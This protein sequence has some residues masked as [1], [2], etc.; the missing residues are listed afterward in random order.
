MIRERKRGERERGERGER[1]EREE[2]ERRERGE[3][4]RLEKAILSHFIAYYLCT[5]FVI[6]ATGSVLVGDKVDVQQEIVI[7]QKSLQAVRPLSKQ[8][9]TKLIDGAYSIREMPKQLHFF[10]SLLIFFLPVALSTKII[11]GSLIDGVRKPTPSEL[12]FGYLQFFGFILVLCI[13]I[14][15][16]ISHFFF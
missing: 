11:A 3:R 14:R 1:E 15:T 7:L 8:S 10:L 16:L 13:I 6:L 9:L 2:R 5:S 12:R 4:D